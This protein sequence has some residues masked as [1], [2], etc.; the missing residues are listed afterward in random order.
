[1]H[2]LLPSVIKDLKKENEILKSEVKIQKDVTNEKNQQIMDLR[3]QVCH[4]LDLKKEK[5]DLKSEVK[6][7]KDVTNARNRIH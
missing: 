4:N 3:S 5:E 2:R 6:I 7:Q 1:M